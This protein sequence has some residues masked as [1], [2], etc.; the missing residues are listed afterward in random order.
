MI[1]ETNSKFRNKR[2]N[3]CLILLFTRWIF[4]RPISTEN[5]KT[6]NLIIQIKQLVTRPFSNIHHL[7]YKFSRKRNNNNSLS[8]RLNF[9]S[10]FSSSHWL[11]SLYSPRVRT[12]QNS[13]GKQKQFRRCTYI[14][15]TE[16]DSGRVAR[17]RV[18]IRMQNPSSQFATR[19]CVWRRNAHKCNTVSRA[20]RSNCARG[21]RVETCREFQWIGSD[22]IGPKL[23]MP[24][25]PLSRP[26]K[27]GT[28]DV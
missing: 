15:H 6:R 12:F 2:I 3:S 5:F 17:R 10:K 19:A 13:N 22:R 20:T 1:D 21:N 7:I 18:T 16:R 26:G 9:P 23:L 8:C 14:F 28:Y 27:T 24:I 11:F 25:T 4:D